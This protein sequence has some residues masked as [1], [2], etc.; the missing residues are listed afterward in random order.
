MCPTYGKCPITVRETFL[1]V[2]RIVFSQ[3]QYDRQTLC[4][5]YRNWTSTTRVTFS[6]T[7]NTTFSIPGLKFL[8]DKILND[9]ET[10]WD[11]PRNKV[12]ADFSLYSSKSKTVLQ[13]LRKSASKIGE[14][15]C[16]TK[17]PIDPMDFWAREIRYKQFES[18]LPSV[19]VDVMDIPAS[20]VPSERLFSISGLLSSGKLFNVKPETLELRV[21]LKTNKYLN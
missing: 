18:E 5:T 2:C 17:A 16:V 11:N 13:K 15:E 7:V 19:A 3:L 6:P 9:E 20:S 12:D 4:L 14:N 8:S 10:N 1:S 21:L